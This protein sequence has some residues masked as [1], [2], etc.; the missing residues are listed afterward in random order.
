MT[1]N[2]RAHLDFNPQTVGGWA[3]SGRNGLTMRGARGEMAS[4]SQPDEPYVEMSKRK[5]LMDLIMDDT[6]RTH[7]GGVCEGG[8]VTAP[9]CDT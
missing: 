5:L 8:G 4:E 1:A 6:I 2:Q 7:E 3:H 9:A